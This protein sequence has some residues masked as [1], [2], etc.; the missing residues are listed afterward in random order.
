[1][2]I[3]INPNDNAYREFIDLAFD[4]CNEFTLVVRKELSLSSNAQKLLQSLKPSLIKVQEQFKW[5]GTTLFVEPALV[6]YYSPDD[7]SKNLLKE[8]STSLHGWV[9]PNLP[10][11]LQFI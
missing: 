6:Y 1:M 8:S 5:P 11:D 7:Y 3:D 4:I 9:Q 2:Y 10:E